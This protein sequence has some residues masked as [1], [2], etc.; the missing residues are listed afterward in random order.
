M[1]TFFKTIKPFFFQELFYF[2]VSL[3][4]VFTIMEIIAP[5]IILAYFNLNYLFLLIIFSGLMTLKN[6]N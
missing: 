2:S 4:I 3:Y 6:N 5:N 1:K